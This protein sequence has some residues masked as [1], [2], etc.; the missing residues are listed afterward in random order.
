M[1]HRDDLIL[2]LDSDD[3]EE[4]PQ[5]PAKVLKKATKAPAAAGDDEATLNPEFS[6][7]LSGALD[8]AWGLEEEADDTIQ[9]GSKTVSREGIAEGMCFNVLAYYPEADYRRRHNREAQGC[10]GPIQA[11][12]TETSD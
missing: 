7:D 6:F 12:E 9:N 3:E 5:R 11:E 1:I 4:K 10:C 8:N 2:T